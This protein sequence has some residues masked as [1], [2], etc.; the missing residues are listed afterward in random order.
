LRKQLEVE[1]Q[2]KGIGGLSFIGPAPA[3]IH[4]LRGRYR[5]QIIVRGPDPSSFLSQLELS[6][7]WVVDIDP[8]G[9]V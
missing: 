5:W 7:G 8:V 4:R 1:S 3:F 9:L 2:A 6:R